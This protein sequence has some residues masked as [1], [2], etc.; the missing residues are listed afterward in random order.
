MKSIHGLI[1]SDN[2]NNSA[3]AVDNA[4]EEKSWINKTNSRK[5]IINFIFASAIQLKSGGL[6]KRLYFT[7]KCLMLIFFL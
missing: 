3:L 2:L 5:K 1:P 4:N 7:Q 6:E